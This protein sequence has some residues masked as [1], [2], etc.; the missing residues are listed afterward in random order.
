M[1]TLAT[2]GLLFAGNFTAMQ[3]VVVLAGLP[4][5]VVLLLYMFALLKTMKAD[6]AAQ[7]TAPQ[8]ALRREAA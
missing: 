8:V 4:F 6:L 5:S 7:Q 2:I 3:T 1:V